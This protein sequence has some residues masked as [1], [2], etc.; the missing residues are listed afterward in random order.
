MTGAAPFRVGKWLPSDQQVLERWLD[1]LI[2]KT[3]AHVKKGDQLGMFHFG[4]LDALPDVPARSP[5]RLRFPRADA[6]ADLQQHPGQRPDRYRGP[7]L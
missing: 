1:D 2:A 3:D 4:G 5:P 7:D 6:G